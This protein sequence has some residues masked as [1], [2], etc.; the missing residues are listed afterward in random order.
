MQVP[1]C[2]SALCRGHACSYSRRA[3]VL[4]GARTR[5]ARWRR[6]RSRL[7]CRRWRPCT[8][9]TAPRSS[10][11]SPTALPCL[12]GAAARSPRCDAYRTHDWSCGRSDVSHWP[13]P[14]LRR[15]R[16]PAACRPWAQCSSRQHRTL[17][18]EL[19]I[20]L[21]PVLLTDADSSDDIFFDKIPI[22]FVKLG[23]Y[24]FVN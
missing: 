4:P 2:C 10:A 3:P 11:V 24:N 16:I 13:E 19:R 7:M 23:P 21:C 18:F 1:A 12:S 20:T 9:S 8:A 15:I 14:S 17:S 6:R 5:A 22:Q